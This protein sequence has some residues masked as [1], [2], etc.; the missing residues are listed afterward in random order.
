MENFSLNGSS[1]IQ[2]HLSSE[3]KQAPEQTEHSACARNLPAA[4][5]RSSSTHLSVFCLIT[6]KR[7]GYLSSHKQVLALSP[8]KF[9][10][11][12]ARL[13]LAVRDSARFLPL[14]LLSEG[15]LWSNATNQK[16]KKPTALS[17]QRELL[18]LIH[19]LW[20]I[21]CQALTVTVENQD[22]PKEG[23]AMPTSKK[24]RRPRAR[25]SEQSRVGLDTNHRLSSKGGTNR[26]TGG[27][28]NKIRTTESLC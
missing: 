16:K 28:D 1:S 14:Q 12:L 19:L 21:C 13:H 3:E 23:A 10:Q 8:G 20:S 6:N 9:I 22:S 11:I 5:W 2:I 27:Q 15:C 26:N 25:M 4:S 17:R 18:L 7:E 24:V